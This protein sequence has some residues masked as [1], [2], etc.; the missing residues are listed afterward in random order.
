[1]I[2]FSIRLSAF[3]ICSVL[4]IH[5]IRLLPKAKLMLLTYPEWM[6]AACHTVFQVNHF[7]IPRAFV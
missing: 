5:E 2:A 4:M 7:V 6:T 3:F 1:M